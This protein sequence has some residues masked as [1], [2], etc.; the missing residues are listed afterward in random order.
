MSLEYK[1]SFDF[2][3]KICKD[4]ITFLKNYNNCFS[5]FQNFLKLLKNFKS[6]EL[7]INIL[8]FL[9][10]L[11]LVILKI[12][13]IDSYD[14]ILKNKYSGKINRSRKGMVTR[15]RR[16]KSIAL[17]HLFVDLRPKLSRSML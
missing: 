7:F 10:K 13:R 3:I 15:D 6:C 8:L 9:Y 12:L 17:S 16:L 4:Y 11:F 5:N 2:V 1:I 14:F